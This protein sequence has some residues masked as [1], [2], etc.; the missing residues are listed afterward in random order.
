MRVNV[1]SQELTDECEIVEKRS[2]TGQVYYGIR[3]F[4]RSPDALHHT[5]D[6]DRSAVTF[7]MAKSDE[8]KSSFVS[9]L[10]RAAVEMES[11]IIRDLARR[12]HVECN[13]N[14]GDMCAVGPDEKQK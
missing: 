7:W 10:R 13:R 2:D 5:K 3:L 11:R 4:L 6:D 12:I 1:Y 8:R 14:G 9:L